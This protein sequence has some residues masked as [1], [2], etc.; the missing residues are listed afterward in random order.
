MSSAADS[1]RLAILSP[2]EIDD[3]YGLPQFTDDHRRLYFDLSP[4]EREAV[5][6]RT[7]SVAVYLALELGYFKAKRQFFAFAQTAVVDDMRY[8]LA[9][10]FPDLPVEAVRAPSRPKRG[11]IQQTVLALFGYRICDGTAKIE[12][13]QKAQRIAALSTQPLYILRES[14]QYLSTERIVALQYTTMQDM[15]GRVVTHERNRVTRLLE[16]TM[17]PAVEKSLDDLLKADEQMYRISALK[18]E[19]KDFSHKEL[20]REVERRQFFQ[21]LHEFAQSFLVVLLQ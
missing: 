14:L 10:Y 17:T 5:D 19:P 13:E 18:R 15:V 3:L 21:P 2:E 9:Q 8:L 7:P 11:D 1:H 16:Q 12:L 4:P 20:K 6:A